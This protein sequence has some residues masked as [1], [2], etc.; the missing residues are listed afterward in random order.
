MVHLEQ[1]KGACF[2]EF[3]KRLWPCFDG[4]G[5]VGQ[6]RLERAN[7]QNITRKADDNMEDKLVVREDP[8]YASGVTSFLMANFWMVRCF[9]LSASWRGY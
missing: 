2:A 1:P 6:D 8:D 7:V 9:M 3:Y 5:V 4:G